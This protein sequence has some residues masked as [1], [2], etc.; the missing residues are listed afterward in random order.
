MPMLGL[1]TIHLQ[2]TYEVQRY[3]STTICFVYFYFGI[4]LYQT[5]FVLQKISETAYCVS[6]SKMNRNGIVELRTSWKYTLHDCTI[7]LTHW[8][9]T[10]IHSIMEI[11]QYEY[12]SG[13]SSVPGVTQPL[14]EPMNQ[15]QWDNMTITRVQ[16]LKMLK[17]LIHKIICISKTFLPHISK[18][19]KMSKCQLLSIHV[20]YSSH[21]LVSIDPSKY[22]QQPLSSAFQ[23]P[24]FCW[25]GCS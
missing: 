3:A 10:T 18:Y 25:I 6:N 22:T 2:M 8:S 4:E 13:N 17:I 16:F 12:D 15:R 9:I 5:A 21:N 1:A 11:G 19:P 14:P 24:Y 20:T 7:P 23:Q